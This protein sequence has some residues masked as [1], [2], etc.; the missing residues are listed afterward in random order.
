M[1]CSQPGKLLQ[2]IEFRG[3]IFKMAGKGNRLEGESSKVDNDWR[4]AQYPSSA[5]IL[6]C[7]MFYRRS[8]GLCLHNA[9]T[10]PVEP[11]PAD[12]TQDSTSVYAW[13]VASGNLKPI[14][15]IG[16][17]YSGMV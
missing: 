8:D 3:M 13:V 4:R 14:R 15:L 10:C 17:G 7:F 5:P 12:R 2:G 11:T 9:E 6:R 1:H 16:R